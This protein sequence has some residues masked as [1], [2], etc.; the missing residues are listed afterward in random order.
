MRLELLEDRST[1][2]LA[3]SGGVVYFL[4][5][6]TGAV[7]DSYPLDPA[8][9]GPLFVAAL[10]GPGADGDVL[11]GAGTGGG[12]RVVRYDYQTGR[13]QWSVFVGDPT[14]RTGV[15]VSDWTGYQT[16][17]S[18]HPEPTNPGDPAAVQLEA[19]R[20]P[21]GL[22]AWLAPAVDVRVTDYATRPPSAEYYPTEQYIRIDAAGW[23]FTRHEV[24]HAVQDRITDAER[25]EWVGLFGGI[26][27]SR[28]PGNGNTPYFQADQHE[29]FAETFALWAGP[30]RGSALAANLTAYFDRLSAAHGW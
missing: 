5:N 8:F 19:S 7:L 3:S 17:L 6:D 24:G 14:S 18:I 15:S 23:R 16:A 21:D 29:A 10:T 11:I 12:P 30:S 1:P 25:A 2:A 26:D 22:E 27:W 13:E 20:L 4:N 28:Y 9:H